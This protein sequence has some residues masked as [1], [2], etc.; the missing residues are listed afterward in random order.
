MQ[1]PEN[2]GLEPPYSAI[3]FSKV[4]QI[5]RKGATVKEKIWIAMLAAVVL[6]TAAARYWTYFPGDVAVTRFVQAHAPV[7]TSWAQ[8]VTATAKS[9]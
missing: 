9:P 1:F 7:S 8:W 2:T 3:G 4:H 6:L 5:S